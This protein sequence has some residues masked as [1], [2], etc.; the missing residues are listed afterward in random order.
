M[1]VVATHTK[2]YFF[3]VIDVGSTLSKGK[4]WSPAGS[5]LAEQR[6]SKLGAS[7]LDPKKFWQMFE[8]LLLSLLRRAN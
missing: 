6:A 1:A 4:L 2:K 7:H 5:L 3:I 8:K